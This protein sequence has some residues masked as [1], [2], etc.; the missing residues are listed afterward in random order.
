MTIDDFG[1]ANISIHALH[2][3]S[4]VQRVGNSLRIVISIH[5]LHEESDER[6]ERAEA[7]RR[8]VISI[9]ALHEESDRVARHALI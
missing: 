6:K 7:I 8:K 2:E 1:Y 9:H 5:A 3:E 4:D